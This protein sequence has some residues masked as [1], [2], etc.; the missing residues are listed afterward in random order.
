MGNIPAA[1]ETQ[2]ATKVGLRARWL[3]VAAWAPELRPL[4]AG[5]AG[6]PSSVRK[7]VVLETVGVGLVEAAA[8]SARLIEKLAPDGVLLVGTAGCYARHKL[9]RQDRQDRQAFAIGSA[10]ICRRIRLLPPVLGRQHCFLPSIVP[11]QARSST[12]LVRA[13]RKA[14]A[15]PMADV[16]CPLA[17]T[18]NKKAA[19]AAAEF[20]GCALENLEAFSVARAAAAAGIPFAAV[21]GIANYVGPAAHAEW[22]IHGDAAAAAACQAV[23]D[24]FR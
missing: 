9:D 13:L 21:L 17:I 2:Y 7:R 14:T 6:L 1:P 3:V 18:A 4:R 20:S 11:T 24:F 12:A 10:A 16:A 8:G 5:L 22:K 15:L 23:L 19:T